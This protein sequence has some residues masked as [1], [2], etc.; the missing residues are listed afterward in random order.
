[1]DPDTT[2]TVEYSTYGALK[3]AF[4]GLR[5]TLLILAFMA[6]LRIRTPEQPPGNSVCCRAWTVLR[7]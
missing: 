5:S 4:Y 3:K 2:L 1:L 7:K 6:L